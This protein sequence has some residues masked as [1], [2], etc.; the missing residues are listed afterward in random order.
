MT[1]KRPNS[2]KI[3]TQVGHDLV[4][5]VSTRRNVFRVRLRV[6]EFT[7]SIFGQEVVPV[8]NFFLR[9]PS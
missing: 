7:D 6:A 8:K 5:Q 2:M 1:Q 4:Y 3:G 9:T